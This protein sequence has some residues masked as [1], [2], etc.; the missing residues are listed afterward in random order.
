MK[1]MSVTRAVLVV[2]FFVLLPIKVKSSGT[3]G[4]QSAIKSATDTTLGRIRSD[5]YLVIKPGSSSRSYFHVGS[6]KIEFMPSDNLMNRLQGNVSGL[7]IT[8][9]GVPGAAP[10]VRIRGFSS[11]VDNNPLY[12]IDGIPSRDVSF[13][14]PADVESVTVLKDASALAVYGSRASGGVISIMTKKDQ[15]G[16]VLNYSTFT[17][18]QLP[19]KGTSGRMLNSE[20]Y[21]NLQWLVYRNDL[22][23]EY[24]PLYGSSSEVKPTL[25]GWAANT[26]WYDAITEPAIIANHDLTLSS[27]TEN[28]SVYAGLGYFSQDGIIIETGIK[29]YTARF[30][31]EARFAGNRIRVGQ[32][33]ALTFRNSHPVD[34]YSEKSPIATGPYRSQSII[35]VKMTQQLTGISRVFM[36]GDWGGTAIASRLG[37]APNTVALL[38]RNKN[39]QFHDLTFFGSG[40]IEVDILPGLMFRSSAGGS[41][42]SGYSVDY[43]MKTYENA[44]NIIT[45]SLAESNYALS[46]WVWTN[47]L[48]YSIKSGVHDLDIVAG[49][50]ALRYG[51]GRTL[52]AKRSGYFSDDVDFRTLDNGAV[53][54]AASSSVSTPTKNL[55]QFIRADYSFD[56]KYL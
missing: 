55:S 53:I 7:T 54:E 37:N 25:P 19:G 47:T 34:N 33:A 28:I 32:T 16:A 46:D 21:A 24:H 11:L 15:H 40:Y 2:V 42:S 8:G 27:R 39:D 49:Y 51:I 26:D 38:D 20:E 50:E 29:K 10:G 23:S 22:T 30:N 56:G 3:G 44:E 52:Y 36:P 5:G 13:L 4:E 1:R 18:L 43:T 9:S 45:S 6:E 14:N 12:V 41:R 31:S 35:P 17:G 48:T